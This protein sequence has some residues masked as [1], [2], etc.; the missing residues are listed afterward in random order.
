MAKERTRAHFREC[1][2]NKDSSVSIVNIDKEDNTVY[3]NVN[4]CNITIVCRQQ[5]NP[6][7]YDRVKDILINSVVG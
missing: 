2:D 7:V 1:T 4:G 5:A 6:D 3:A